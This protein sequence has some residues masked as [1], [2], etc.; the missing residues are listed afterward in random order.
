MDYRIITSDIDGAEV[1]CTVFGSGSRALVIIPGLNIKSVT[2]SAAAVAD[3]YKCFAEDYTVYLIDRRRVIPE[4]LTIKDFA[5]DTA[6]VMEKLGI[7][8]ADVFGTS[9][10]GMVAQ[11]LALGYPSL[12]RSLALGSSASRL[13]PEAQEV[14]SRWCTLAESGNIDALSRDF[15]S[16][17][18][19]AGFAEK[20]GE[21][22]VRMLQ[23]CTAEE[24]ERFVNCTR[25]TDGFDITKSVGAISCP[26][27]VLGVENDAVLTGEA[28][29]ETAR[30]TGAQIYMYGEPYAHAVY[31]EAP[32]YKTRL[33]NFFESI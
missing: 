31:D 12:V 4:G 5:D 27:L 2:L 26:V 13:Y 32:D 1:D 28:S 11:L 20:Y 10:G 33:I 25:A 19:S 6:K 8:Q 16:K 7:Y 21:L 15:I 17:V 29:R 18:Y 24:L 23:D 22:F 14:C 30:L 9:Q 3:A